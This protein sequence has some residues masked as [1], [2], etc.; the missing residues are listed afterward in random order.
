M[1]EVQN[2]RKIYNVFCPLRCICFT[3]NL[4]RIDLRLIQFT[5]YNLS[6]DIYIKCYFSMEVNFA[7][8]MT[9]TTIGRAGLFTY[10]PTRFI[11]I[12]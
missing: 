9:H 3:K 10:L 12:Y 11:P 8:E 6:D 7:Y 5:F 2:E 1:Y 4:K